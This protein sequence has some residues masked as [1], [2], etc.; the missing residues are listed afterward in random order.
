MDIICALIKEKS[1]GQM[2]AFNFPSMANTKEDKRILKILEGIYIKS[3]EPQKGPEKFEYIERYEK[4]V[5]YL[6]MDN[7][8]TILLL[9]SGSMSDEDVRAASVQL[10][11]RLLL[12]PQHFFIGKYN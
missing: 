2:A 5:G 1:T 11:D 6:E 12:D 7:Q 4:E 8:Y 9:A 10:H 3:E